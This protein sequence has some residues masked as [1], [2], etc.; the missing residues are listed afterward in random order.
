MRRMLLIRL[1]RASIPIISFA[2]NMLRDRADETP[3]PIDDLLAEGLLQSLKV[4]EEIL[5]DV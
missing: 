5:K 3:N 2:I 1:A 4:V